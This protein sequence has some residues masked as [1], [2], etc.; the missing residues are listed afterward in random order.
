MLLPVTSCFL[1]FVLLAVTILSIRVS[2]LRKTLKIPSGDEGNIT[3]RRRI[4]A[5]SNF[6]ENTP[7]MLFIILVLEYIQAPTFLLIGTAVTFAISRVSHIISMGLGGKAN[8]LGA[9]LLFI[10]MM[11]QHLLFIIL[12]IWLFIKVLF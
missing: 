3:L 7:F 9:F 10:A 8:K 11:P 12:S 1:S 6:I 5:H 4:Q 2:M